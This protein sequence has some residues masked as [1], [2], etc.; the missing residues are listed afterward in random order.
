M[1]YFFQFLSFLPALAVGMSSVILF[2][3]CYSYKWMIVPCI[4]NVIGCVYLM[5]NTGNIYDNI[6]QLFRRL[7]DEKQS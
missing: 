2:M 4:F 3:L 7:K 5:D 1:K 6:L